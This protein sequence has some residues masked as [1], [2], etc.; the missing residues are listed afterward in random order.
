MVVLKPWGC[1][2]IV[3]GRPFPGT[4]PLG[5]STGETGRASRLDAVRQSGAAA[6]A[7]QCGVRR[8]DKA[9]A[10]GE[11]RPVGRV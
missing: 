3:G 8:A 9:S 6:E 5:A 11:Q 4:A 1:M 2:E 7:R 10:V